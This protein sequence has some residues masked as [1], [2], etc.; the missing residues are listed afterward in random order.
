MT[1]TEMKIGDEL[2]QT[3]EDKKG[4]G[5]IKN[6]LILGTIAI[7]TFVVLGLVTKNIERH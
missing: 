5:R 7:T 2:R 4:K 1:I 6:I 3:V